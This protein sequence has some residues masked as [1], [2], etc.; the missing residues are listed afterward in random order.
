MILADKIIQLRKKCGWSQEELAEKLGVSRQAVSKWEGAQSVPDIDKILSLARAFGVSTDYLLMDEIE[1]PEASAPETDTESS[2]RR[3][4]LAEAN[5]YLSL[6]ESSAGKIA[7]A[8]YLC[9]V[10][11]I[12]LFLLAVMSE[13]GKISLSEN[14]SAFIGLAVLFVFV[15]AAVVIF[16][17][18]A[19]KC[20]HFEFL[21]KEPF[22]TEYGVSGMVRERQKL[23]RDSYTRSNLIGTVICI[24]SPIAL[25]VGAFSEDELLYVIM[26][27]VTMMLEGVGVIFFIKAGVKWAAMQRLLREGEFSPRE[28][29]KSKLQGIVAGIYWPLVTALYLLLLFIGDTSMMSWVVWPVSGVIFAAIMVLCSVFEKKDK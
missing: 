4:S 29:E 15:T 22:E 25:F 23:F 14:T 20:S 8:T 18:S 7:Y 13:L 6:R 27:A 10:S 24:L 3:V 21:E 11:P 2:V 12:C 9:I 28:K 26:L 16:I 19:A 1:M 5:E 17:S